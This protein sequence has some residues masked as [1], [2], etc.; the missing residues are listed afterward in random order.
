MAMQKLVFNPNFELKLNL[1]LSL[2]DANVKAYK[3]PK[4][5][6]FELYAG[7]DNKFYW[8]LRATNGRLILRSTKGFKV[9]E[10]AVRNIYCVC[11]HGTDIYNYDVESKNQKG[12]SEYYLL[13]DET[14][15]NIGISGNGNGYALSEPKDEYN[16]A[17][18]WQ[19]VR[20]GIS[21]GINSC[22]ANLQAI[23][24]SEKPILDYTF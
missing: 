17:L 11:K 3:Y 10:N 23:M 8:V 24:E 6:R 4:N 9:K 22:A 21:K 15:K 14:G 2:F 19:V 7:K 20:N 5:A 18:K 1:K 16:I 12:M 13:I